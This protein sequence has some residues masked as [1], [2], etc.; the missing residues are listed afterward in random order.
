MSSDAF[1]PTCVAD[2]Q[3]LTDKEHMEMV[4]NMIRLTINTWMT[5]KPR[6]ETY[7]VVVDAKNVYG[8]IIRKFPLPLKDFRTICR[9]D[10]QEILDISIDS[11][12]GFT[13][14]VHLHYPEELYDDHRDFPLAPT[15]ETISYKDIRH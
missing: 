9:K 12:L 10:L 15:K 4:E 8:G 7:G 11:Q 6:E 3:L 5:S 1:L 2:I 13:S 14:E